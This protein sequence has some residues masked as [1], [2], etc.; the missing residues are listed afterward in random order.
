MSDKVFW[1]LLGAE[2]VVWIVLFVLL[3]MPKMS[4]YDS[5]TD[6]L[7]KQQK[8]LREYS[9]RVDRDLPTKDLLDAEEKFNASWE[10]QCAA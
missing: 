9:K 8:S 7:R 3:V 6:K 10:K 2:V 1:S 4:E 5:V